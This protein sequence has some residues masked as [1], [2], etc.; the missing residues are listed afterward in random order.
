MG[1]RQ[2]GCRS[3]A[4]GPV[5]FSAALFSTPG[6]EANEDPRFRRLIFS[7]A[8]IASDNSFYYSGARYHI[9]GN[10]DEG[11]WVLE[12]SGGRGTYNY[13]TQNVPG[14]AVNATFNIADAAIGYGYRWDQGRVIGFIGIHRES[15]KLF[16]LDPGN[17]NQG[18]ETGISGK[19]DL[20]VKPT[21]NVLITLFGSVTS[22]FSGY[23]ANAFAGYRF[24]AQDSL[25]IGPEF[26]FAGNNS[27]SAQHVGLRASGIRFRKLSFAV[28]A[29]FSNDP[30]SSSG[31]YGS[32][33][34]WYK[35]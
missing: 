29:G 10:T 11:G 12:L 24:L 1:L 13:L 2:K 8:S 34:S 18:S 22:V 9:S 21:E 27:Y 5:L 31:A 6:A 25:F 4:A 7:G 32:L 3:F 19:V 30:D 17:L 26:G 14:G 23:Y 15:H 20:W 33:S 16:P 35:L 28:S